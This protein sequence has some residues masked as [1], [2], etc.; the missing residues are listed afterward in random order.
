M[1]HKLPALLWLPQTSTEKLRGLTAATDMALSIQDFV[2]LALVFCVVTASMGDNT[3]LPKAFSQLEN[4]VKVSQEEIK[5][6]H[7]LIGDL[8]KRLQQLETK[9]EFCEVQ[10][11]PT[12]PIL[13]DY[14]PVDYSFYMLFVSHYDIPPHG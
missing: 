14:L 12:V 2:Q 4:K 9:G 5:S 11:Q 10:I 3:D 6:L 8:E 7:Q 1:T 13:Q